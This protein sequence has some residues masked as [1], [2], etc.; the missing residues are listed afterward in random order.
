M[1]LVYGDTHYC[2]IDKPLPEGPKSPT[3]A[4]RHNFTQLETFGPPDLCWIRVRVVPGNPNILMFEPK[5][6]QN[7]NRYDNFKKNCRPSLMKRFPVRTI[8]VPEGDSTRSMFWA[9][10]L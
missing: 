7:R 4:A 6:L 2:R 8:V 3:T 5:V 9:F 10:P 1:V